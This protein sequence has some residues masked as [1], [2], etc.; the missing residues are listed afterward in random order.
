M[1]SRIVCNITGLVNDDGDQ[2]TKVDPVIV[3]YHFDDLPE[4]MVI[5]NIS[6]YGAYPNLLKRMSPDDLYSQIKHAII[7]MEGSGIE[8]HVN[9]VTIL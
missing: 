6:V 2:T 9:T 3:S 7:D 1:T 4:G 8:F 5:K